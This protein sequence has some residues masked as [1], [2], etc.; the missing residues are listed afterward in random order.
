MLYQATRGCQ[1]I[2]V[3][4]SLF[5]VSLILASK[6]ADQV[7]ERKPR[8]CFGCDQS[9][10][11]CHRYMSP[12]PVDPHTVC[13]R[14]RRLKYNLPKDWICT[15][16]N[17][18]IQCQTWPDAQWDLYEARYKYADR[19]RR[20]TSSESGCDPS[21][22]KKS[23][24][25]SKSTGRLALTEYRSP[26]PD[27]RRGASPVRTKTFLSSTDLVALARLQEESMD[28]HSQTVRSAAREQAPTVGGNSPFQSQADDRPSAEGCSGVRSVDRS[29]TDR[30]QGTPKRSADRSQ[31]DRK[32]RGERS[33]DQSWYDS[34]AA[35][36][37][38]NLNS[39][40]KSPG[41]D[42]ISDEFSG[43]EDHTYARQ[44]SQTHQKLPRPLKRPRSHDESLSTN[45][46]TDPANLV[47]EEPPSKQKRG[48]DNPIRGKGPG[49]TSDHGSPKGVHGSDF[50]G[51]ETERSTSC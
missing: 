49:C 28:A 13:I 2:K 16:F 12:E 45:R 21:P 46:A 40:T 33:P 51:R 3:G 18:C 37:I 15:R 9:N 4:I 32:H 30:R 1:V 41:I 35:T 42:D 25:L 19:K 20:S 8:V 43:S 22:L 26:L 48:G 34:K 47:Q 17:R 10:F 36:G 31:G 27:T 6:M 44:G 50:A 14:C 5:N 24:S 39:G 11:R 29:Q 23:K 38:R 7:I